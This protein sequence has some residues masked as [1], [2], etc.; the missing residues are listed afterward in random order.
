MSIRQLAAALNLSH[1]EIKR[2]MASLGIV[3][4]PQG[5]GRPTLLSPADQDAIA[6]EG[7]P[8]TAP[9]PPLPTVEAV[10]VGGE[11]NLYRPTPLVTTGRD[12]HLARATAAAAMDSHLASF[13][14]NREAFKDALLARAKEDGAQLG[15]AMFHTQLGTALKTY[16]ALQSHAGGELGVVG[17]SPDTGAAA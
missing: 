8:T 13:T 5:Q 7:M 9:L 12:G 17:E 2:R 10:P 11:L 14:A 3:G 15:A 4:N 16:E 6:G 1:T